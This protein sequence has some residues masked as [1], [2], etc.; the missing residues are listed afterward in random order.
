MAHRTCKSSRS[1][2]DPVQ[3]SEK[4]SKARVFG[5]RAVPTQLLADGSCLRGRE[6]NMSSMKEQMTELLLKEVFAYD[7]RHSRS[8]LQKQSQA[9]DDAVTTRREV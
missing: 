6:E 8:S 2:I 7:R 4:I 5:T 9:K 3:D 1:L